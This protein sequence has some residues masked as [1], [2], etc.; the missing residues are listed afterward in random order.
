MYYDKYSKMTAAGTEAD[1]AE[2]DCWLKAELCV[3]A[4]WPY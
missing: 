2:D 3:V 1:L 4:R